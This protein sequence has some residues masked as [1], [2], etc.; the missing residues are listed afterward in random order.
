MPNK[1]LSLF[2]PQRAGKPHIV[3]LYAIIGNVTLFGR[4][5]PAEIVYRMLVKSFSFVGGREYSALN[6]K[7]YVIPSVLKSVHGRPI[8]IPAN[9]RNISFA[10]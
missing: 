9:L 2:I 5:K 7:Y 3:Y 1:L 8:K 10:R 4:Y 6:F